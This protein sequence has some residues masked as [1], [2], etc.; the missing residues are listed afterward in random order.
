MA[1]FLGIAVLGFALV[2]GFLVTYASYQREDDVE[3]EKLPLTAH[4]QAEMRQFSSM[5]EGEA[6][7]EQK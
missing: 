4:A 6:V 2:V 3:W 5:D 7:I 1:N